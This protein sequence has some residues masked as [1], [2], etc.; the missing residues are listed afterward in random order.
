MMKI[1]L[2]DPRLAELTEHPDVLIMNWDEAV[3]QEGFHYPRAPV[4]DYQN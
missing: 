1:K 4:S 2:K 3:W